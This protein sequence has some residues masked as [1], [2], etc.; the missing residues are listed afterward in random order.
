MPVIASAADIAEDYFVVLLHLRIEANLAVV[1]AGQAV[2]AC[3]PGVQQ[4]LLS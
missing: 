3:P 2:L 4:P 1:V